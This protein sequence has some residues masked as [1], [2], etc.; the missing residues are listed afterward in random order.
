MLAGSIRVRTILAFNQ[1]PRS[2]QPGHP[3]MGKCSKYQRCYLAEGYRTEL[4]TALWAHVVRQGLTFCYL[5]FHV[6]LG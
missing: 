4:S 2:T 3:S 6:Q 5:T 1:P